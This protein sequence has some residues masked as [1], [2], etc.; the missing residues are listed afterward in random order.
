MGQTRWFG[1]CARRECK[2]HPFLIEGVSSVKRR[3]YPT[4]RC[5]AGNFCF[6]TMPTN[7]KRSKS[8][9][10]HASVKGAIPHINDVLSYHVNKFDV[11]NN[12]TCGNA[13]QSPMLG[14]RRLEKL[15]FEKRGKGAVVKKEMALALG[16]Q[17]SYHRAGQ[18][19]P[20]FCYRGN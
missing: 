16:L 14:M 8:T 15:R 12:V 6:S 5:G 7:L 1:R 3:V 17:R 13:K 2:L 11:Q 19:F 18:A 10:A 4:I 9:P 20:S